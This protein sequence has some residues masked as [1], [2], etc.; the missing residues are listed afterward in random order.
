MCVICIYHGLFVSLSLLFFFTCS[1]QI[2]HPS[3][4]TVYIFQHEEESEF[5]I[6]SQFT[7]KFSYKYLLFWTGL[8]RQV[9][10]NCTMSP[11][12]KAQGWKV[13]RD[14]RHLFQWPQNVFKMSFDG[15][16]SMIILYVTYFPVVIERLR[17][18][19]YTSFVCSKCLKLTELHWYCAV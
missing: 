7:V 9:K 17:N 6:R 1:I 2:N 14:M 16:Y 8:S 18:V 11:F 12:R 15:C 5:V 4:Q 13:L 19:F 10:M 3:N